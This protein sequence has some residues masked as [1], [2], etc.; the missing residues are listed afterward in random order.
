MSRDNTCDHVHERVGECDSIDIPRSR[1]QRAPLTAVVSR[2]IDAGHSYRRMHRPI[3][4]DR[5][6][7]ERARYP[8]RDRPAIGHRRLLQSRGTRASG[9]GRN[10]ASARPYP[11]H[12]P[13]RHGSRSI[14]G[15]M[16][17]KSRQCA[18][19][20]AFSGECRLR[21]LRPSSSDGNRAR[22]CQDRNSRRK[23]AGHG[24]AAPW[25]VAAARFRRR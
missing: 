21:F 6:W 19:T 13:G 16:S 9:A 7:S 23:S 4:R 20:T 18:Q 24:V 15:E 14:C 12:P 1:R 22:G 17:T 25:R 11:F 8:A 3:P 5:L 2:P 10:R